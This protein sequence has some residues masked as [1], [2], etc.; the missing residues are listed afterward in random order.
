L[1]SHRRDHAEWLMSILYRPRALYACIVRTARNDW[2]I[3]AVST[4]CR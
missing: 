3:Q 1:R 4:P 2:I